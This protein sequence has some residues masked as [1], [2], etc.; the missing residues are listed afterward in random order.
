MFDSNNQQPSK[1]GRSKMDLRTHCVSSRLN[2]AELVRLDELRGRTPRGEWMRLAML[3]AL[4]PCIPPLNA[5]AWVALSR[6]SSNLNQI[7]QLLHLNGFDTDLLDVI[8]NELHDF[9]CALL[10]VGQGSQQ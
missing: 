2:S 5:D 3:D 4:P 1:S 7:T 6:A 8:Y 10:S 9:R